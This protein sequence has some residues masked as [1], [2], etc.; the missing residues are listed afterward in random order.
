M[1]TRKD[2]VAAYA[3]RSGLSDQWAA[4]GLIDCGAGR[5]LA[6]MPCD[7]GDE[8]CKGWAMLSADGLD[9]HFRFSAPVELRN[10][11]IKACQE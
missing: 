3:K 8:N 1:V 5:T 2:F 11:Y 7:C 9:H 6:A 4:L 10:A